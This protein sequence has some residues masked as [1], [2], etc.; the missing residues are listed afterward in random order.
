VNP[1]QTVNIR[2]VSPAN[3]AI[4]F[5]GII[6]EAPLGMSELA[7]SVPAQ[8]SITIPSNINACRRYMLTAIGRTAAGVELQ[9]STIDIDIERPDTPVSIISF[10]FPSR[11]LEAKP[12]EQPF[13]LIIL[14]TFS[15]RSSIE[16]TESSYVTYQSNNT[17]VATVDG[18]GG[19]TAVAP[20]EASI[21]VT[22]KNPKGGSVQ[23]SVPVTVEPP[24][25]D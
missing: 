1:G 9:E 2:V 15:D 25:T 23:V 19:L 22:Y 17:A 20:G 10:Q 12:T 21:K 18:R 4:S 24:S 7:K 3:A 5:V 13:P 6:G 11:T 14:A 8:F 16:V